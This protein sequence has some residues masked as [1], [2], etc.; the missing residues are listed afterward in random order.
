MWISNDYLHDHISLSKLTIVIRDRLDLFGDINVATADLFLSHSLLE[1]KEEDILRLQK[2]FG[3]LVNW[4]R[5][6]GRY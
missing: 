4:L 6:H 5:S 1:G 3:K 2:S